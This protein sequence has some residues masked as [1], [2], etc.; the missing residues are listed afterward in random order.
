MI[1]YMKR[2]YNGKIYNTENIQN[3]LELKFKDR[4]TS[5]YSRSLSTT[6]SSGNIYNF[7]PSTDYTNTFTASTDS[8]ND[9]L[10]INNEKIYKRFIGKTKAGNFVELLKEYEGETIKNEKIEY[11]YGSKD[12]VL[13]TL[14][15]YYNYDDEYDKEIEEFI[16]NELGIK[17][18]VG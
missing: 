8:S 14:E 17:L 10:T 15:S 6:F 11:I 1:I 9:I 16:E 3:V 12:D 5:Y 18:E 13:H 7:T 2:L 4:S